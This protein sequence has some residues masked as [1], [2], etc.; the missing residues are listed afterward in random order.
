ASLHTKKDISPSSVRIEL[1]DKLSLFHSGFGIAHS[2]QIAEKPEQW[3][4]YSSEDQ[5]GPFVIGNFSILP[6]TDLIGRRENFQQAAFLVY[7]FL[8]QFTRAESHFSDSNHDVSLSFP[9]S[10]EFRINLSVTGGGGK[11][12]KG[13]LKEDG[14][15]MVEYLGQLSSKDVVF[16]FPRLRQAVQ[17]Y[18][19]SGKPFS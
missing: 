17:Q 3:E 12:A 6:E 9:S 1:S 14:K 19:Q 8:R 7:D 11:I 15:I 16:H 5:Y 13:T 2:L 18:F 10:D 4:V